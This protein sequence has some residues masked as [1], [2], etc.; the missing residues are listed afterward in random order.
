MLIELFG[1][2][3]ELMKNPVDWL[4]YQYYLEN[5]SIPVTAIN[6]GVMADAFGAVP[7]TGPSEVGPMTGGPAILDGDFEAAQAAGV[8]PQF[9]ALGQALAQNPGRPSV[10]GVE[11]YAAPQ[12][13]A[14]YDIGGVEQMLEQSRSAVAAEMPELTQFMGSPTA[15][16]PAPTPP[17][18][19]TTNQATS[20][21]SNLPSIPG[22]QNPQTSSGIYTGQGGQTQPMEQLIRGLAQQLGI[23]EA[24]A[25]KVSG[26]GN[27]TPAYSKEAIANAPVMQA[28]KS[29]AS[30]M[31][32]FRTGQAPTTAS[33]TAAATGPGLG[34]R[35]GQDLN[36]G[37]MINNT[38]GNKGLIQGAVMADGHDWD[39]F[40]QQ[41]LKASPISPYEVGAFGRRR[42]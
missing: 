28:I 40:M 41:A 27:M 18:G 8:Q 14:Q 19:G 33:P 7:Q 24:E 2:G 5:L 25:W 23:S 34:L 9:V 37:L 38:Q 11:Q 17:V 31:S 4:A 39:T 21:V 12:A 29:G 36:A 22:A 26:A 3:V 32:Q 6:M 20:V 35:G 16:A 15:T 13:M 42:N 30:S 10:T 1:M